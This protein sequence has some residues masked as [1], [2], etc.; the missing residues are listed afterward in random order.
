MSKG[1]DFKEIMKFA[2]TYISVCIGSG[3]ATGQEIM[4]FFSAHG[5]ISILSNMVCMIILA[6]CGASLLEIGKTVRLKS[7]NDIF[8]YLCGN[9]VGGV[10]GIFQD[11]YAYIFLL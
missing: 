9:Y 8:T 6:Y 3:F 11:I 4:Q 10:G 2:G 7:S 5:M 1:T